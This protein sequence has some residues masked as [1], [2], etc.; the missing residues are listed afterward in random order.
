MHARTWSMA[1]HIVILM[2]SC[3]VG[4]VLD[5]PP[6]EVDVREAVSASA[7][8]LAH[9]ARGAVHQPRHQLRVLAMAGVEAL[10]GP[11]PEATSEGK[12]TGLDGCF[13]FCFMSRRVPS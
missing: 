4:S 9:H 3:C 7:A 10:Q 6:V 12:T 11:Q 1:A 5:A 8:A 2:L 13:S